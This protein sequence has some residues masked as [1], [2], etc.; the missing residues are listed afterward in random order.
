MD[1]LDNETLERLAEAAHKVWMEGKLRDGWK[2]GPETDKARKIHNCLV[3]YDQLSE[4]DKESD[5]DMIR[6][7]QE[8]LKAAGYKMVKADKQ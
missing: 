2:Y 5:R 6:G 1:D 7:I 4:S 3:P 8:I